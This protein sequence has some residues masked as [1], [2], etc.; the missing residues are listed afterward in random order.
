MGKHSA[1]SHRRSA[2]VAASVITAVSAGSMAAPVS[3]Q[4]IDDLIEQIESV[5]HE[6]TAKNED[7]KE[8]EDEVASAQESLNALTEAA[9]DANDAA[10]TAT[11]SKDGFQTEVNGIA[12]TKYRNVQNDS[13]VTT[14]ESGDPQTVID[15]AS[16]LGIISRN[17]ERTLGDL[18]TA[19]ETAASKANAAN[20]AVAEAEFLRN[21]L[22][23]KLK[24]LEEERDD[25][26]DQIAD[27]EAQVDA[28]SE[29]DRE[30]WENKNNPVEEPDLSEA[31][32][33]PAGTAGVVGA[34]MSKLGSPYGWG[35]A[36]PNQFDCSGLMYW[37]YA[38]QGKS[39]PRTSQ[40]QISGGQS[41]SL[42]DLQ[43]GDIIGYYPGVTHVGMYIGNGQVV[44]ASDYGIPVQVVPYDSMPISGASRY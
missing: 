19:S 32:T 33:A 20:I 21:Q 15:R 38:Q 11:S 22:D 7:V 17:T 30:A 16:Y 29:A 24:T 9:N 41:V 5:S 42:S 2:V 35:A 31:D 39:I 44:H 8:L 13:F 40:A 23:S 12:M 26:E 28:L 1:P 10:G 6:A 18:Q 37:S 34:A 27:I 4:E 3:A 25:L 14:L 43:P 36:G